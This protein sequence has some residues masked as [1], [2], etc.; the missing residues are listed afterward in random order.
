MLFCENFQLSGS[1]IEE[2]SYKTSISRHPPLA[3]FETSPVE[4]MTSPGLTLRSRNRVLPI[5]PRTSFQ[6]SK[7]ANRF[8]LPV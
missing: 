4:K 7:K 3:A 6:I 8:P 5:L 2:I 1:D